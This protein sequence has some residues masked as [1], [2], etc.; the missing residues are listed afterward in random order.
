[1][2]EHL[3]GAIVIG[4]LGAPTMCPQWGPREL[5]CELAVRPEVFFS[6]CLFR[7]DGVGV[8]DGS[9][10]KGVRQPAERSAE[11]KLS[12]GV[13]VD[14]HFSVVALTVGQGTAT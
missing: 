5:D 12:V 9:L 7:I 8:V 3:A 4:P 2:G 10:T 6:L 13:D 11:M 14:R 1:M